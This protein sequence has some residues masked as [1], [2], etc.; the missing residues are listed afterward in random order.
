MSARRL[1]DN[2]RF[3]IQEAILRRRLIKRK[4]NRALTD[5]LAFAVDHGRPFP[6]GDSLVREAVFSVDTWRMEQKY[7]EQLLACV[8]VYLCSNVQTSQSQE[9]RVWLR[10][11][12]NLA[13]QIDVL[14][15]VISRALLTAHVTGKLGELSEE[16]EDYLLG[17]YLRAYKGILTEAGP[18][19]QHELLPVL[20]EFATIAQL[21]EPRESYLRLLKRWAEHKQSRP[22]ML[23]E[24]TDEQAF[25]APIHGIGSPHCVCVTRFCD[26]SQRKKPLTVRLSYAGAT[27]DAVVNSQIFSSL[28]SAALLCDVEPTFVTLVG[29]TLSV[30]SSRHNSAF[31]YSEKSILDVRISPIGPIHPDPVIP[32]LGMDVQDAMELLSLSS[33]HL[34]LSTDLVAVKIGDFE[35]AYRLETQVVSALQ[36]KDGEFEVIKSKVYPPEETGMIHV[37]PFWHRDADGKAVPIEIEIPYH[38]LNPEQVFNLL[39]FSRQAYMQQ[40]IAAGHR[41]RAFAQQTYDEEASRVSKWEL[42]SE[43]EREAENKRRP[44]TPLTHYYDFKLGILIP[45][46]PS[47]Q[48]TVSYEDLMTIYVPQARDKA[49]EYAERFTVLCNQLE[50]LNEDGGKADVLTFKLLFDSMLRKARLPI[51]HAKFQEEY[52]RWI[53]LRSDL[54]W[55]ALPLCHNE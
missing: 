44:K 14:N 54:V 18:E 40:L 28:F 31:S 15:P 2:L 12:R 38:L 16:E 37:M 19:D 8:E 51:A 13:H 11:C 41:R 34:Q 17:C 10:E 29:C 3:S 5:A 39:R 21:I 36:S 27:G 35:E 55:K 9:W 1:V 22:R 42:L 46:D 53:K 24:M 25:H 47:E 26:L 20:F 49:K 33:N 7:Q 30:S 6:I 4:D 45:I 32:S 50:K 48:E 52:S 23:T 43:E